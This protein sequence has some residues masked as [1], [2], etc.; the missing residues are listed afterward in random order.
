MK[1]FLQFKLIHFGDINIMVYHILAIVG[2]VIVTKLALLLLRRFFKRQIKVGQFDEGRAWAFY[3]IIKY[4][5]IVA[6][7]AIGLE[8][9]GVQLTLLLAG[10]AALL[11]GFGLGVQQQFNDLVS[12]LVLLFEGTV[13]IGDIVELEGLVGKITEIN[14]R[15]SQVVTRDG[16]IIIVPNSKLVSDKVI[17]WSHNRQ[18]TRF[19]VKVGVAYGTDVKKATAL[20]EQAA[21]NHPEVAKKPQPFARFIDFGN[22]SLDLEIRFWCKNMW[23]I[24]SIKSDIRFE[25]YDL[26]HKNGIE[27]PFPQTDIH[28]KS[29]HT[30]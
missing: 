26:F 21:T 12:G 29:N 14:I 30:Q 25:I 8:L 19:V 4:V 11:V 17:N 10:S 6:A 9:I 27:I 16:I 7:I 23:Q 5:I 28:I 15:T 13:S 22:S 24:E 20:I 18:S 3:Q 1:E 2:V